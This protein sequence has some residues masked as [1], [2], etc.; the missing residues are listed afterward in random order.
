MLPYATFLL[1]SL[2][3]LA[4]IQFASCGLLATGLK[5]SI[6]TGASLGGLG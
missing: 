6:A 2:S 3:Q 4:L 5:R 1:Y